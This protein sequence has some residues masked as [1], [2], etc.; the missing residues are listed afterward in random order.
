MRKLKLREK[1]ERGRMRYCPKGVGMGQIDTVLFAFS[2][3]NNNEQTENKIIYK[4]A[5]SPRLPARPTEASLQGFLF[6][7]TMP[8]LIILLLYEPYRLI[9]PTPPPHHRSVF[10]IQPYFSLHSFLN[11]WTNNCLQDRHHPP[12]FIRG[13]IR[14]IVFQDRPNYSTFLNSLSLPAY[15]YPFTFGKSLV[16]CDEIPLFGDAL[17]MARQERIVS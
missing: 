15:L 9:P 10:Y 5:A 11:P 17:K 2:W 13:Q 6:L 8:S 7:L 14:C 12:P 3:V 1:G 4:T 16:Y